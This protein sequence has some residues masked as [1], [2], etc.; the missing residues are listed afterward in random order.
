MLP[1]AERFGV[2]LM[3]GDTNAWDGPFV[4]CVTLLG[5]A[6]A[7]RSCAGARLGDAILVTGPLG[8]SILGRHLRPE[9]RIREALALHE[10]A[11]LHALIDI[12][13]GLVSDLGHSSKRAAASARSS[14]RARSRSTRMLDSSASETAG[15][16]SNT[17]CTT[18]KTSSSASQ[19]RPRMPSNGWHPPQ[20]LRCST[21]LGRSAPDLACGSACPADHCSP[22]RLRGLTIF[23][24]IMR[25][26]TDEES[27]VAR[28]CRSHH[29]R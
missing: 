23:A 18:A 19:R 6:H 3:G 5:E 10:L 20:S 26:H 15:R 21:E 2:E 1:L 11:P 7:G 9:P 24:P 8:G 16:H 4:I 29:D 22:S 12:S 14:T 25:E 27:P 17:P 28:A 13:D